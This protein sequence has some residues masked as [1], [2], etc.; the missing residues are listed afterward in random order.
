MTR[1]DIE[2][3]Q[4]EGEAGLVDLERLAKALGY[5][6]RYQTATDATGPTGPTGPTGATGP[7]GPTGA[8]GPTGPTG[9]T[10]ATGPTGPTDAMLSDN[11]GIIGALYNFVMEGQEND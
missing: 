10:G 3:L 5:T 6:N 4:I 9:A 11:P 7:T 1:K 8:T 2:R